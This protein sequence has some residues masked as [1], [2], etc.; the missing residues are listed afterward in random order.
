MLHGNEFH[1][2]LT[3]F[4]AQLKLSHVTK[5]IY[6]GQCKELQTIQGR[7]LRNFMLYVYEG[8]NVLKSFPL[9]L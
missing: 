7:K 3:I 1:L 8:K 6:E 4:A 5:N 2:L 9:L